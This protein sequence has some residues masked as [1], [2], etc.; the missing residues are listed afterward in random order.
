MGQTAIRN[1]KDKSQSQITCNMQL[2]YIIYIVFV[3][4]W[5]SFWC[6]QR[7]IFA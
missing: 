1:K 4:F 7:M 5:F 3:F 6:C 2:F